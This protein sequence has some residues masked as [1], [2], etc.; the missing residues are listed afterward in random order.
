MNKVF[1]TAV[2]AFASLSA[3]AQFYVSAS[4]GYSFSAVESKMGTKTT[5]GG[6]EN[7]YGSYGE[8]THTQV[9][10]G[11]FFNDKWGIETAVGYLHGAD[12][13]SILVDIPGQT[14]VDVKSRGRAF[15][16]SISTVYNITEHFYGRAGALTKIA[17]KTEVVGKI[18]ADLPAGLLNPLAPAGATA[19]LD[20]D[21]TREF[22]GRFPIGFI[23]A[24]GYKHEILK[25]LQVFGEVEYLGISVTRNTSEISDFS[26]TLAGQD[27]SREKL[28]QVVGGNPLLKASFGQ[29]LPLINNEINY[30]DS[31]TLQEAQAQD[32]LATKQL[33][34]TVPYSSWGLNFGF[35][36]TFGN[37]KKKE[38]EAKI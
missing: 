3:S 15:G 24:I 26:A 29:L 13:T 37:G 36:Y 34:Q 12:Q 16:L 30:E 25:N 4:S 22:K 6:V 5:L 38:A 28:L 18:K 33:S 19:P 23:G 27:L 14:F 2:I 8:G 1:L 11:Y 9:R 32:P 10:G 35:T 7:T 21:L 31:L 20:I 17:G